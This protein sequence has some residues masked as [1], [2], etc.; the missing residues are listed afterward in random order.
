M[1]YVSALVIIDINL[2]RVG[3]VGGVRKLYLGVACFFTASEG[4]GKVR[5]IDRGSS[6]RLCALEKERYL[7]ALMRGCVLS[8]VDLVIARA[9][10]VYRA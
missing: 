2:H 8:D 4:C 6:D 5:G 1:V 10:K 7:L 9:P 3:A